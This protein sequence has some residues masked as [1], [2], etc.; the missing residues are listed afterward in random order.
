[1]YCKGSQNILVLQTLTAL[2]IRKRVLVS[3]CFAFVTYMLLS[4]SFSLLYINTCVSL[5]YRQDKFLISISVNE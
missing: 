2:F 1:M 3:F 5:V 4:S